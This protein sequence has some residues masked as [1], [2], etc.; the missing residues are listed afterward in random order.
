M[1]T[2]GILNALIGVWFIIAPWVI[3]FSDQSGALW[4]SIIFGIIQVIV[5]LWGADKPGWN[6]WQNWIS[7]ITGVWFVAFPFIYSL[8]DGA[9][10]SSV[11]LGLITIVFSLWNL[12]S[13]LNS[14]AEG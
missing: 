5:S 12:G 14:K 11:I 4:S 10:L 13:K 9:V 8:T 6:S 3:G 7:V 1:K 2:R